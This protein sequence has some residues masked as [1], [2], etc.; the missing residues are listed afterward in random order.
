MRSSQLQQHTA[1]DFGRFLKSWNQTPRAV[2]AVA[3]SGRLLAKIM[4]TGLRS[5]AR[6]LEL[7]AGTGTLTTAILGSGVAA[8]DLTLVERDP[9]FVKILQ[10]RFPTCRVLQ[11]D[12]MALNELVDAE[13]G[14]FDFIVSGLRSRSASCSSGCVMRFGRV[15]ACISSRT[16]AGVRSVASCGAPSGSS[17]RCSGWRLSTCRRH[18]SIDCDGSERPDLAVGDAWRHSET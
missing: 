5:G 6:V 8:K 15:A 14:T 2:G 12:A 3:P 7:G 13:A 11:G 18:S 16:P 9:Q 1:D 17:H 4:A 10:R